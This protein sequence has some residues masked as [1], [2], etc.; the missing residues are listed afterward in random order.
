MP[1][2]ADERTWNEVREILDAEIAALPE[3]YRLPLVLC[4]LQD[5][6][7]DEAAR[8]IGCPVG[9]LRGRLDRGRERL[10]RRLARYGLPL[11]APIL[12]VGVPSPVPAALAAR[13]VLVAMTRAETAPSALVAFGRLALRWRA[14]SVAPVVALVAFAIGAAI[15]PNDAPPASA[16]LPHAPGAVTAAPEPAVDA[17]GDPLPPGAIARLGSARFHH[18]DNVQRVIVGADGKLVASEAWGYKMWAADTGK[19]VPLWGGL[20][21]RVLE[22]DWVVLVPA[23]EG[24]AA[25]V[26]EQTGTRL[27]DPTTGAR[28]RTLPPIKPF[29][30]TPGIAPNGKTLVAVHQVRAPGDNRSTLRVWDA[31]T[32]QWTDLDRAPGNP[33]QNA[34]YFS[35]DSKTLAYHMLDG[36]VDVWDLSAGKCVL[37]L[38]ATRPQALEPVAL[39]ADG[40]LL[41]RHAAAKLQVWNVKTGKELPA[42]ADPPELFGYGELAFSPDSKVLVGTKDQFT[43]RLWD[44][45]AGK[46]LR[47]ISSHSS[48]LRSVVL[49]SDGKRLYAADGNGVCV[50][51]PAT[52][53]PLDDTGGHRYTIA[54]A[55]WSPD[56][57]QLVSGGGYTDNIARVWDP[58]TGRKMSELVGHKSGVES[59]A[60]SPDGA[61]L[62]TGS[63]DGTARLWDPTTGKELHSFAAR[64]GMVYALAFTP[65]GRFLVTG[66]RK[67]LHVWDVAERKEARSLPT[68]GLLVTQITFLRG[69]RSVLVLDNKSGARLIDFATGREDVQPMAG[70][71]GRAAIPVWSGNG[72]LANVDMDGTTHVIDASTGREILAF[73]GPAR[74]PDQ[75]H[76]RGIMGL[77]VAPDG[78]TVALAHRRSVVRA[79]EIAT[80]VDRL[81]EVR[82]YEVASGTERLRFAGHVDDVMGVRFSPDGTRLCSFAADRSL[83]IWD[84]TGARLAPAPA[85]S[86]ADA[87]WADLMSADAGKGFAAIRSLVAD[88][89]TALLLVSAGVK[90]APAADPKVVAELIAKLGSDGF[91]EREGASKELAALAPT[92]IKQLRDAAGK[93]DS[94][95]VR[96]RLTEL[97]LGASGPKLSGDRLR[98]AR[99]VEILERIGTSEAQKV[100]AGLAAGAPGAM[101]TEDAVAALARV[102]RKK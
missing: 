5:A 93:S 43:I 100:L 4:Y 81:G 30:L 91:A 18:G 49:S 63:Q 66:G 23:G 101:L 79:H 71:E 20:K 102:K 31:G 33:H 96:K 14:V 51:D 88:P 62:A 74:D 38:P 9:V 19:A 50:W 75:P 87:A 25:V 77:T 60:Y 89:P 11:A 68:T 97:V 16:P 36:A 10:R 85:P 37:R 41:A 45:V 7:H 39:S 56:G 46:K 84:V 3:R 15:Q 78:R 13:T 6:T 72:H 55:A 8:Q 59:V 1:P 69:N 92:A 40:G 95:E 67:A 27:V 32:E 22:G 80:A 76:Y 17:L 24:L 98:A 86:G 99:A 2:A 12:V 73:S 47:D 82:V 53:K 58:N 94:P 57:K 64:D 61:V 52:G 65:D 21:K 90:P 34:F 70:A 28:L 35:A 29:P 83:L 54:A 42:M 48:M 26:Q 44:V